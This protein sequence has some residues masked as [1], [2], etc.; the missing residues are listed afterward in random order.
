MRGKP[1]L[2]LIEALIEDMTP[3]LPPNVREVRARMTPHG[4]LQ[5]WAVPLDAAPDADD[6]FLETHAGAAGGLISSRGPEAPFG[7]GTW[8][9]SLPTSLA[10]RLAVTDALD[11]IKE[12]VRRVATT[13]PA[14]DAAAKAKIQDSGVLV[15]F[16][17]AT[18]HQ[19]LPATHIAFPR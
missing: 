16:E 6:D 8:T 17:D 3:H 1:A 7:V 11:L 9:L 2:D 18:G 14:A 19:V 4:S 12:A 5:V 10:F 13:C 15:W